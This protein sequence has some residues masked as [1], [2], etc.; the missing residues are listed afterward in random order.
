MNMRTVAHRA[1]VSSATVSRVINGS[2]LV[3]PKTAEHVR[4]VIEEMQFIPNPIATT[5]K[6]GWSRTYGL[7]IPDITNPFY[8]DFLHSFEELLVK[9]D[10][11]LML[12][13]VGSSADALVHSIRRMLM[14]QVDGVVLLA[15]EFDTRAVEPLLT[16]K[17]PVVTADRRRAQ[18]GI[19]DVAIDFE[20]G[21]LQAIAH[22]ASLGH[23][24]IA[25]VG[26]T[27]GLR[28]SMVR[29]TAFRRALEAHGIP[30]QQALLREGDYR[31]E[32]GEAAAR[33]LLAQKERPSAIVTANDLTAL[34]VVRELH[35]AG[36]HLPQEM[37]VVG[38][39][40]IAMS[41]LLFPPLTTIRIDRRQIA[42][43]CIEALEYTKA[44]LSKQGKRF[45]VEATLV[46]RGT[47][48]APFRARRRSAP[49]GA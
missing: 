16:R 42:A 21:Y 8:P 5:L 12:A 34:G 49:S 23:T 15:S 40:D 13:T 32:G 14:R 24:D 18:Q 44:N 33:S 28:T 36:L 31:V 6:Y 38:L 11:E 48:A 41:D 10:H 3:N 9:I 37:S 45:S 19:S 22:L 17:V 4:R 27:R 47:T 30:V 26:G 39:D 25:F 1:G 35:R 7:I 46:V 20:G 43:A 29:L 2:P